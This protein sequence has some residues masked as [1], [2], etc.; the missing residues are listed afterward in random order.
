MLTSNL[1]EPVWSDIV[2]LGRPFLK[3]HGLKNHFIIVDGRE[4]S[5]APSPD[6]IA[7]IC[8]VEAGVGA[9]QL[10]VIEP[11]TST[12][13]A[14]GAYARMRIYN[15]DGGEAPTCGNATRCVAELLLKESGT[16]QIVIET[17]GG[18]LRCWRSEASGQISVAMGIV[19]S[20]WHAIPL[21]QATDTLNVRM[22]HGPLQLAVALNIGNP[23]LVFFVDDLRCIDIPVHA[24]QAQQDPLLPESANIG[25]AQIIGET[26]IRLTVWERPGILTKACGSGACCAVAAARAKGL[27]KSNIVTVHMPGGALT[28]EQ[29]DK[30]QLTLTGPT[31]VAFAGNL[32]E[33][34]EAYNG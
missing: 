10:L 9:D 8:N 19:N 13:A 24:A 29:D 23:H 15:V 27:I 3:M 21:A 20:D 14:L 2:K 18:N 12:G 34:H 4:R 11:A 32:L 30:G 7:E 5:F 16:S 25:V 28:I 33:T 17:G 31:V 6:V 26:A 1:P 22:N